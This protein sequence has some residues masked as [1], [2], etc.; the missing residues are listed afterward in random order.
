MIQILAVAD[1]LH[2]EV[3]LEDNFDSKFEGWELI[4]D[5]DEHAFIKDSHY[6]MEN[7]SS[8]RW[9][10]Y[11][12]K[13][14]VKPREN[15]I[16]RADIELINSFRKF[17]QYGL[18]WGFDKEHEELNKFVVSTDN[19]DF[20]V[21]K[22]QKN[23]QYIKHRFSNRFEKDKFETNKQFFSIVK[24]ESY[25]YFFLNKYDR[26]VYVMHMSQMFMEGDRFGFYVEPGI[27]IRCDSIKVKRLI[28]EP[29]FGGNIWMPLNGASMPLGSE[30]LRG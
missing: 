1:I 19:D 16:I 29:N 22:F 25:Y 7:K 23:H 13:L 12:K 8:N 20:T 4:E 14:P 27:M 2:Q 5:E 24:L 30:I 26:P 10:F 21:A 3:V 9:M 17:G 18:V 15:F 11:H 6:W 28:T